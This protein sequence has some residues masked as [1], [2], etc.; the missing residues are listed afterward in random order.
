MKLL[1]KIF[2]SENV[3]KA[4][5]SGIDKAFYSNEEKADY[6]LKFLDAYEPFKLAQRLL[7][8]FVTSVYLLVFV[9]AAGLMIWGGI[10]ENELYINTS[11]DLMKLNN[12]TLGWPVITILAFYFAGGT[13]NTLRQMKKRQP[14]E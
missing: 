6:H 8:L 3:I 2:G 9:V 10:A 5:I 4:G 13:V 14:N 12:E 1:G 11:S 7:A